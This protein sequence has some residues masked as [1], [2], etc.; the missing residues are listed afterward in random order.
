MELREETDWE[1]QQTVDLVLS[2][3][4][5]RAKLLD[6]QEAGKFLGS[7]QEQMGGLHCLVVHHRW[8]CNGIEFCHKR[9]KQQATP[10]VVL[11]LRIMIELI[12]TSKEYAVVYK[13]HAMVKVFTTIVIDVVTNCQIHITGESW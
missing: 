2:D 8:F 7:E 5:K 13:L 3:I 12:Q 6:M 10:L 4:A 11:F 9:E 1:G